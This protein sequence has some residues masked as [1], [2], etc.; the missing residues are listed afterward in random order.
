MAETA[1]KRQVQTHQVLSSFLGVSDKLVSR[2][3][4]AMSAAGL[5]AVC[6]ARILKEGADMWGVPSTSVLI[7]SNHGLGRRR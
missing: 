4:V 6:E 5:Y 7:A 1:V 2:L 3:A